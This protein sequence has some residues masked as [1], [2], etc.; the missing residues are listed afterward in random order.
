MQGIKDYTVDV[1]SLDAVNDGRED[2][3]D[4]SGT[5]EVHEMERQFLE[6]IGEELKFLN[7]LGKVDITELIQHVSY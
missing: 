7:I 1:V 2:L 6:L 5:V 3:F 4:V